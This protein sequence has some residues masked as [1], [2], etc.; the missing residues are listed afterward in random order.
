MRNA[1]LIFRL[2]LF[3]YVRSFQLSAGKVFAQNAADISVFFQLLFNGISLLQHV[4][5]TVPVLRMHRAEQDPALLPGDLFFCLRHQAVLQL[6]SPKIGMDS[7]CVHMYDA[8]QHFFAEIQIIPQI[9][10]PEPWMNDAENACGPAAG[11]CQPEFQTARLHQR[12]GLIIRVNKEP[13]GVGHGLFD[14]M[15]KRNIC[16]KILHLPFAD[17]DIH[18]LPPAVKDGWGAYSKLLVIS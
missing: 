8:A 13:V 12:M 4:L 5:K 18:G 14:L 3:L 10:R 6:K 2:E 17:G 16:L 15:Q 7:G 9:E 1:S 11:F